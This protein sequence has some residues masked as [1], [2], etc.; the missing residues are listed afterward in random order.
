MTMKITG[1]W[2][3]RISFPLPAADSGYYLYFS[4]YTDKREALMLQPHQGL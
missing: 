4:K 2:E 3:K 1:Y